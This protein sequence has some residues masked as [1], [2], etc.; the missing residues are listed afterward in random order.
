MSTLVR[1]IAIIHG[2]TVF[3]ATKTRGRWGGICELL[4]KSQ[5]PVGFVV[6]TIGLDLILF[7]PVV[8]IRGET[9]LQLTLS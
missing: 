7:D 6:F 2:R 9:N 1:G 4:D 8:V 5:P 3:P